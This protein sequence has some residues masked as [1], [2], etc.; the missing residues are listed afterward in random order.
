MGRH[1]GFLAGNKTV[2]IGFVFLK[3]I[4][5]KVGRFRGEEW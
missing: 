4:A 1:E 5:G 2:M 3:L